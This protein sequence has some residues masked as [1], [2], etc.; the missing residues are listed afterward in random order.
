MDISIHLFT[1]SNTG[2]LLCSVS[3][4]VYNYMAPQ[5]F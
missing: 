5:Y 4:V 3:V 1:P 2:D